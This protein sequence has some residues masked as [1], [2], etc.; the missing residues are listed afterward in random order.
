ME[1]VKCSNPECGRRISDNE[2][3]DSEQ[4]VLENK[5]RHCGK[6]VRLY[7][8]PDGI[9][10]RLHKRKSGRDNTLLFLCVK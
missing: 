7:C 9:E 10:T 6:Q 3:V 5:C 4:T 2:E 1:I 8:D